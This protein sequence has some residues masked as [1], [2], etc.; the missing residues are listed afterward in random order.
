MLADRH[1]GANPLLLISKPERQ[2]DTQHEQALA[3]TCV[4]EERNRRHQKQGNCSKCYLFS[5]LQGDQ[6]RQHHDYCQKADVGDDKQHRFAWFR[7][8]L[9]SRT[10]A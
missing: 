10:A 1:S 7:K 2:N 9:F 4:E 8:A 3:L 6:F 5:K